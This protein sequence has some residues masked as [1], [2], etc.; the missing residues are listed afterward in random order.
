MTT[1]EDVAGQR[2]DL[3]II[4]GGAPGLFAAADAAARGLSVVLIDKADFG[5][6]PSWPDQRTIGGGLQSFREGRLSL[7][8]RQIAERRIWARLAPHLLRPLPFL[9]GTYRWTRRSKLLAK[10]GFRTYDLLGRKRNAG[11]SQELHLPKARLE[12]AAATR[13][14]FPGVAPVGLTGGAIWYD[15]QARYPER[16]TWALALN[17]RKHGATLLNYVEATAAIR[18]GTGVVIGA[19]IRDVL[20]GATADLQAAATLVATP[21]GALSALAALGIAGPDMPV[22]RTMDV[23]LNRPARD[24][25]LVAPSRAGHF[26]TAIPWHGHLLV[27]THLSRRPV[28]AQAGGPP[29]EAIEAFLS[30]VNEAFPHLSAERRDIR[31]LYSGLVPADSH[32]PT[33]ERLR[34]PRVVSHARDGAPGVTSLVGAEFTTARWAAERAVDA[35]CADLTRKAARSLAHDRALPHAGIADVEGRLLETLREIRVSLDR[36]VIEHLIGWYGTEAST[37]VR[38]A[39]AQGLTER[40][41]SDGPILAGEVAYAVDHEAAARL[42]DVILRRT[43]IGAAGHPGAAAVSAV[44]RVMSARLGWT[45]DR[46]AAELA[47]LDATY[48]TL[49]ASVR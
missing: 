26:M 4:G 13:R 14:L 39:T 20:S 11:V 10:A 2:Y 22:L 16:L 6:D 19:Q 1:L 9:A 7:A 41:A 37:V 43:P 36:D 29:D 17:A 24:I 18:T 38:Y 21:G 28:N 40:I 27:G 35:V 33:V 48:R 34:L 42:T 3:L 15:Y 23:L 31:L 49:I 25:A 30:D 45:P 47:D 8:K 12:S 5:G 32:G 44:A 46:V